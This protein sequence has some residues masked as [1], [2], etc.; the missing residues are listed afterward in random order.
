MPF[1]VPTPE[2]PLTRSSYQYWNN[3]LKDGY[4]WATP[5]RAYE[6]IHRGLIDEHQYE[7]RQSSRGPSLEHR[8][9]ATGARAIP[10]G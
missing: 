8:Y 4:I 2:T 6:F 3:H 1:E 9:K 5:N 7:S 10:P